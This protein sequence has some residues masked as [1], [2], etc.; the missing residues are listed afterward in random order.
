MV[1][2]P[3]V[4]SPSAPETSW[5]VT[6]KVDIALREWPDGTVLHDEA[7][8]QLQCLSPV[9]G[10]LMTLLLAGPSWTASGLAAELLGETPTPNDVEMV[11]NA[12][13]T[14]SSLDLI[15]RVAA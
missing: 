10:T 7:T 4:P 9:A 1:E 5:S 11:E 2:T 13:S 12:L 15:E 6:R 14:F 8:G 3:L